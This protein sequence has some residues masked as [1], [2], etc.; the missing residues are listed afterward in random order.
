MGDSR[1]EQTEEFR[2]GV[3]F[4]R[5]M[6]AIGIAILGSLTVAFAYPAQKL[7]VA[8]LSSR[9]AAIISGSVC[10]TIILLYLFLITYKDRKNSDTELWVRDL[11]VDISIGLA[12]LIVFKFFTLL[13]PPFHGSDKVSFIIT[14]IEGIGLGVSLMVS[15]TTNAI[16]STK[17]RIIRDIDTLKSAAVKEVRVL[18]DVVQKTDHGRLAIRFQQ[19]VGTLASWVDQF[20]LIGA[21]VIQDYEH[22]LVGL[23]DDKPLKIENEEI[24]TAL[25]TFVLDRVKEGTQLRAL[26]MPNAS[27]RLSHIGEALRRYQPEFLSR[28]IDLRKCYVFFDETHYSSKALDNYWIGNIGP[29]VEAAAILM[30]DQQL[31]HVHRI[32]T[33]ERV[34]WIDTSESHR[35]SDLNIGGIDFTFT[36]S[37]GHL[38][39]LIW[40]ERDSADCC[41]IVTQRDHSGAFVCGYVW[42][43]SSAHRSAV[44]RFLDD[45][46]VNCSKRWEAV[47]PVF[48]AF[49]NAVTIRD[50]K[51][52]ANVWVTEMVPVASRVDEWFYGW[53]PE[54]L[55]ESPSK[56]KD[57]LTKARKESLGRSLVWRYSKEV[58]DFK[59]LSM[60]RIYLLSVKRSEDNFE[61]AKYLAATMTLNALYNIEVRAVFFDELTGSE[62]DL[63][64]CML[65]WEASESTSTDIRPGSWVYYCGVPRP[66]EPEF[67]WSGDDERI[68]RYEALWDD[69]E[70]AYM[71]TEIVEQ[72]VGTIDGERLQ[73]FTAQ[74]RTIVEKAL[75]K[76]DEALRWGA[77]ERLRLLVRS[78]NER[79]RID[80]LLR[81]PPMDIQAGKSSNVMD[82]S[83]RVT[84]EN[85]IGSAAMPAPAPG[86]P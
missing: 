13:Y 61:L 48:C 73:D 1:V 58:N 35:P 27:A 42:P 45:V 81:R 17:S 77:A 69:N 41:L 82:V 76:P 67:Q 78:G 57:V 20:F 50:S 10:L 83:T 65:S 11:F 47:D 86:A 62:G 31:A 16:A 32:K 21:D 52:R 2:P 26:L 51:P 84:W 25:T 29:L 3:R 37:V 23:V 28:N 80:N 30:P 9:T 54:A 19:P 7:T 70:R 8:G 24:A 46:D 14:S 5:Y 66:N 64:D 4:V 40:I 79:Y 12:V 85:I 39:D 22:R 38:T 63:L 72:L 74:V 53:H 75:S 71:L 44:G 33:A 59:Q 56:T 68:R 36:T 55:E 18:H 6:C 15:L 60:R 34:K 49:S 43:E